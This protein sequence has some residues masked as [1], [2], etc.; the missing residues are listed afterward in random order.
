MNRPCKNK[1]HVAIRKI[2]KCHPN[3]AIDTEPLFTLDLEE[4]AEHKWQYVISWFG[5]AKEAI[6]ET[7]KYKRYCSIIIIK[8]SKK[9]RLMYGS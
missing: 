3:I 6:A 8:R 5:N 9:T 1:R 2:L 7:E 4:E